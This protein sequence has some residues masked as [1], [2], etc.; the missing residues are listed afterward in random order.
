MAFEQCQRIGGEGVGEF[1]EIDLPIAIGID[2]VDQEVA[3]DRAAAEQLGDA[4]EAERQAEVDLRAEDQFRPLG[5]AGLAVG[6]VEAVGEQAGIGEAAERELLQAAGIEAEAEIGGDADRTLDLG[7]QRQE[8]RVGDGDAGE[9]GQ[10]ADKISRGIEVAAEAEAHRRQVDPQQVAMLAEQEA[11]RRAC[12]RD[13]R[14]RDRV[15]GTRQEVFEFGTGGVIGELRGEIIGQVVA[16]GA[17]GDAGGGQRE[18]GIADI[19]QDLEVAHREGAGRDR[20]A[21]EEIR[22]A[23]QPVRRVQQIQR[24]GQI[25]AG[26]ADLDDV[27]QRDL[28]VRPDLAIVVDDVVERLGARQQL[29]EGD[30]GAQHLHDLAQRREHG[31]EVGQEGG[32]EI[33]DETAEIEVHIEEGEGRRRAA[34]AIGAGGE[35]PAQQEIEGE[36]RQQVGTEVG[37]QV[38]AQIQFAGGLHIEEVGAVDHLAEAQPA[39]RILQVEACRQ[40]DMVAVQRR[41]GEAHQVVQGGGRRQV[42]R[43]GRQRQRE[44]RSGGADEEAVRGQPVQAHGEVEMVVER[45]V[46]AATGLDGDVAEGQVVGQRLGEAEQRVAGEVERHLAAGVQHLHEIRAEAGDLQ[47]GV[48]RRLHRRRFL[49]AGERVQR[50]NRPVAI[51]A[52]R[53][54]RVLPG[55]QGAVQAGAEQR[56]FPRIKVPRQ[57]VLH[58]GEHGVEPSAERLDLRLTEHAGTLPREAGL[59]QAG[60]FGHQGNLRPDLHPPREGAVVLHQHECDEVSRPG[61]AVPPQRRVSTAPHAAG[62]LRKASMALCTMGSRR[63]LG[64]DA[65]PGGR[66]RPGGAAGCG[67]DRHAGPRLG[68][69]WV[70]AQECNRPA[71]RPAKK[72]RVMR[73]VGRNLQPR[74]DLAGGCFYNGTDDSESRPCPRPSAPLG[75]SG[76]CGAGAGCP[77]GPGAGNR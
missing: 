64:A 69:P 53:R 45:E 49:A 67:L 65:R 25:E 56:Q 24:I 44:F 61:R 71:A 51:A 59:R 1:V 70:A 3:G 20:A 14:R 41:D 47:R 38:K 63:G 13:D 6:D 27:E 73:V 7:E 5:A 39:I 28:A 55:L 26:M 35:A 68:R 15:G 50:S 58:T 74:M 29:E 16:G 32:Q 60:R 37:R 9:V 17:G 22:K 8:Q 2:E 31:L 12:I 36:A 4:A 75:A 23:R 43:G 33:L 30:I 66:H 52:D 57:P 34:D 76:L 62:P 48:E 21:G 40:V 77:G 10:V 11:Q 46:D 18:G 72:M 54:E 42:R 19:R